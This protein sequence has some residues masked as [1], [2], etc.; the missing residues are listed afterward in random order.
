MYPD[1]AGAEP[2]R[3]SKWMR[4]VVAGLAFGAGLLLPLL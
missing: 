3:Q 4:W 1:M 2:R